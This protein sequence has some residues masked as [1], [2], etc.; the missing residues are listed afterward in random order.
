MR[1]WAAS[2]LAMVLASHG[3]WAQT[4]AS[5]VQ[6]LVNRA[7]TDFKEGRYG[8]SL[9]LFTEAWKVT[10]DKRLLYMIGRCHEELGQ[11]QQALEAFERFLVGEAPQDAR[12]KAL[13]H[14][15]V[16]REQLAR[17]TLVVEVHPAD[18][19]VLVD[20]AVL[21]KGPRVELSVQAGSRTVQVRAPGHT[22]TSK[23]V[24]VPGA[25]RA[26]VSVTL[27]PIGGPV[28]SFDP[29][30]ATGIGAD[31]PAY[32][33]W[34]WA[35][36]GVGA[37]LVIGGSVSYALGEEDHRSIV[38]AGGYD[39][40]VVQM[41][42]AR[43]LELEARGDDLKLAGGILWGIGG[44]A[45]ATAATLLVLDAEAQAPVSVGAGAG[46]GGAG[47]WVTGSF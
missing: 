13:D 17:G 28:A 40:G 41:G 45:L 2:G 42:R 24:D 18:A 19:E 27:A 5:A 16:V 34:G 14:I 21:G 23:S 10:N 30:L 4:D 15:R 8:A 9:A 39:A 47:L 1:R 36:L 31:E 6:E 38:D 26:V 43:A 3:A 11:P 33:T 7:T 44:A 20:G 22:A 25:G 37:A 12:E 32:G 35:T 29:S 46:Q